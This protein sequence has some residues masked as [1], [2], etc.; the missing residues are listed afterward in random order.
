MRTYACGITHMMLLA[1]SSISASSHTTTGAFPPN[2]KVIGVRLAAQVC[3]SSCP[4]RVEPVKDEWKCISTVRYYSRNQVSLTSKV[5][6]ANG[7]FLNECLGD[8]RCILSGDVDYIQDS[9]WQTSVEEQLSNIDVCLW[10]EFTGL[11]DDNVSSSQRVDDR[12]HRQNTWRIPR[13][14]K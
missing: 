8:G 10:R 5:D 14:W 13:S 3:A 1:A 4:T 9:L 12:S 6:L 2:S 11:Q 7:F